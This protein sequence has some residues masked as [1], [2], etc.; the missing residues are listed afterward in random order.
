MK[1]HEV[2]VYILERKVPL[3]VENEWESQVWWHMPVI[4][5]LER[6]KQGDNPPPF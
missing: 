6:I 1:S 3:H 4:L 5:G 2:K